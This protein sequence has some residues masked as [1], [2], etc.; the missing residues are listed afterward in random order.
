MNRATVARLAAASMA[1]DESQ[2]NL[3]GAVQPRRDSAF[4]FGCST[5]KKPATI[6]GIGAPARP[7]S[8]PR[9]NITC[10][11]SAARRRRNRDGRVLAAKGLGRGGLRTARSPG[12]NGGRHLVLDLAFGQAHPAVAHPW[13]VRDAAVVGRCGLRQEGIQHV[14]GVVQEVVV[15]VTHPDVDLALQLRRQC[16]SA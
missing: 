12:C 5:S 1:G 8:R 7:P 4:S 10:T 3:R 13:A 11:G 15:G 16:G 9:R 6:G 14:D 2:N